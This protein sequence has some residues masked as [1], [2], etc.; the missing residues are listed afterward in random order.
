MGQ[1]AGGGWEIE[2]PGS[3]AGLCVVWEGGIIR[4]RGEVETWSRKTSRGMTAVS[5]GT[6]G[7]NEA[8][9]HRAV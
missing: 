8:A 5:G 4:S 6:C 2:D 3:N 7:R 1:E 9:N